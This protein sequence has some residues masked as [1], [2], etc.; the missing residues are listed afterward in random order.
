MKDDKF[1]EPGFMSLAA[2]AAGDDKEKLEKAANIAKA[3]KDVTDS[4]KCEQAVKL[5]KCMEEHAKKEGL[6]MEQK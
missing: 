4:D 6:K 2:M 5:G 1:S 3:C